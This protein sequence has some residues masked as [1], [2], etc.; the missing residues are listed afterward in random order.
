MEETSIR[1]WSQDEGQKKQ[2]YVK[3]GKNAIDDDEAMP[4]QE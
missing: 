4:T 3:D 2:R 1:R